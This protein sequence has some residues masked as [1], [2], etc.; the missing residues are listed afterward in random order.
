[1]AQILSVYKK[2]KGKKSV[3]NTHIKN[4]KI[5]TSRKNN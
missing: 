4:H 1:M 2:I 5:K 3:F